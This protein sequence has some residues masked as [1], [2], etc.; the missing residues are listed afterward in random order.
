MAALD[1]SPATPRPALR[2]LHVVYVVNV[3]WFFLSHRLVLAQ[4]ARDAGARVTVL[5]ADTGRGQQILDEGFSFVP[6]P[7]TRRGRNPLR[8]PLMSVRLGRLYRHLRPDIIHHVTIKPVLYGSLA[9]RTICRRAGVVNA[10]SGLGFAFSVQERAR[11]LRALVTWLYRIAL[12]HPNSRTIFQNPADRAL[13]VDSGLVPAEGAVLIPGSGVD[14]ARFTDSS[15]PSG[16]PVVMLASRM[17]WDKGVREFVAAAREVKQRRP[18]VRFVLVGGLD[19]GN[20][21]AVGA[22]QLDTWTTEG[23]VEWWG[24]R[25]DMERVLPQATVI[26]L[27]SYREGLPK[28]LLE[29]AAC[30]RPL[31]A[32]DVPGCRDVVRDEENGLL[33][34]P[35]DSHALAA[36]VET[37]LADPVRMRRFGEVNRSRALAD[38]GLP[39]VVDATMGVYEAVAPHAVDAAGV[40]G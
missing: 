16:T 11:T 15:L 32:T 24:H 6:V 20:P 4:A 10:V 1:A 8:E 33:V 40:G 5:A 7:F 9:A 3:D 26:A 12:R 38:F 14:C 21:T 18:D 17:L 36:A 39:M 31:I 34:P 13:F 29:A 37:L 27:P 28:V 2:G 23:V 25:D 30:G 22:S 35:R 19:P